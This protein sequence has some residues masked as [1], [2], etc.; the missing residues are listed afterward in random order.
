MPKQ[1]LPAERSVNTTLPSSRKSIANKPNTPTTDKPKLPHERDQSV[2]MTDGTPD[3]EVQQAYEDVKQGQQDTDR[4]A[5]AQ[6]AYQK[7]KK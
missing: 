1:T 4:G 2:D 7:L 6:R 5:E 3:K